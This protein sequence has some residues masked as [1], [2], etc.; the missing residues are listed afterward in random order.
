MY[1]YNKITFILNI[2]A[3][4][5]NQQKISS[6][7]LLALVQELLVNIEHE[8]NESLNKMAKYKKGKKNRNKKTAW[9]HSVCLFPNLILR[10]VILDHLESKEKLHLLIT[11]K[12]NV[13]KKRRK[14]S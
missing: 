12:E 1:T 13:A 7:L 5:N 2:L 9:L 11:I 14:F 10:Y 6:V 8:N 3:N 4:K